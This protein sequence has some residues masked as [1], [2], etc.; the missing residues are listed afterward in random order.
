M[1]KEWVKLSHLTGYKRKDEKAI[2]V[3]Q[4]DN[5]KGVIGSKQKDLPFQV[6]VGE[7]GKNPKTLKKNIKTKKQAL[8]I[9]K[10]YTTSKKYWK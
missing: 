7:E 4:F 6:V 10:N 9:A 2:V 8:S 1:A 5:P 3:V